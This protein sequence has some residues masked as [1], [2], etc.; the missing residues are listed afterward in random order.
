MFLKTF[1]P[2]QHSRYL[3][4]VSNVWFR[5]YQ[6]PNPE[7]LKEL[8]AAVGNPV[9]IECD[10]NKTLVAQFIDLVKAKVPED[11]KD[12]SVSK[13]SVAYRP[14][15]A[16]AVGDATDVLPIKAEVDTTIA[17]VLENS[18]EA[19]SAKNPLIVLIPQSKFAASTSTKQVLSVL[20]YRRRKF[21]LSYY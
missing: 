9:L 14:K 6:V 21:R 1:N 2:R 5:V 11:L 16:L 8:G 15:D 20:L 7:H 4:A 17:T 10:I 3:S 13:M 12:I 19:I 18:K